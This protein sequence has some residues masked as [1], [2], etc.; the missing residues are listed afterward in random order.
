MLDDDLEQFNKFL[1]TNKND[2]RQAI[3]AAEDETKKKQEKQFEIKQLN[4]LRS[5]L[6]TKI[7]QKAENLDEFW[8]YKTFLDNITPKE[9]VDAQ[10]KRN[11]KKDNDNKQ[12]KSSESMS[13]DVFLSNICK[14]LIIKDPTTYKDLATRYNIS[15]NTHIL[16]ILDES[17]EEFEPYFKKPE[18]LEQ[19]FID[20]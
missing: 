4:E 8:E 17:D 12:R 16:N 15:L 3:K 18:Q 7:S 2:S 6:Q 13:N 5:D 9:Y 19:I 20:L 14:N 1:E 11:A 10:K